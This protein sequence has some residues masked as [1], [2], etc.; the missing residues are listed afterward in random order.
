ML[1]NP[2]KNF[3]PFNRLRFPL[4]VYTWQKKFVFFAQKQLKMKTLEHFPKKISTK[5]KHQLCILWKGETSPSGQVAFLLHTVRPWDTRPLHKRISQI[6]HF[7]LGPKKFD[8]YW[9]CHYFS[10]IHVFLDVTKWKLLDV[11]FWN[12]KHCI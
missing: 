3:S 1:S 2:W 12:L 4:W 9:F 10:Q 11:V 7:W 5:A 6:H 8:L